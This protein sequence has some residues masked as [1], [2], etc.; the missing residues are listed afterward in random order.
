VKNIRAEEEAMT[1]T[2]NI[3]VA[4]AVLGAAFGTSYPTGQR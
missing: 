1:K 2:E 4:L 3:Q